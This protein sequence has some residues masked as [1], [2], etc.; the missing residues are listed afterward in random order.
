M[1]RADAQ[2]AGRQIP[3]GS[4]ARCRQHASAFAAG[5]LTGSCG[6]LPY[7]KGH[8][9]LIA[10]MIASCPSSTTCVLTTSAGP[11]CSP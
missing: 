1:I 7:R 9:R 3:P 6:Q 5:G 10:E 2:A 4:D 8:R 11:A